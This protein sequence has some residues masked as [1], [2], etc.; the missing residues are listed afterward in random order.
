MQY[1]HN[2]SSFSF[3]LNAFGL[4][5]IDCECIYRIYEDLKVIELSDWFL[6][7]MCI[8]HLNIPINISGMLMWLNATQYVESRP[9]QLCQ[10]FTTVNLKWYEKCI[11]PQ[12]EN[13]L[14]IQTDHI[15]VK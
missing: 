11:N 15:L 4:K 12:P 14:L 7:W 9:V 3:I 5:I 13:N 8:A 1:F 6:V 2:K 10:Q